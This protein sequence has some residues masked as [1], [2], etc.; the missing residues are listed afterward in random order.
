MPALCLLLKYTNV[1]IVYL[2]GMSKFPRADDIPPTAANPQL[3][4]EIYNTQLTFKSCFGT[5][6]IWFTIEIDIE[7]TTE[8]LPYFKC[9]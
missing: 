6:S 3:F 2:K 5:F 1:N 7:K 9:I 8:S 4:A